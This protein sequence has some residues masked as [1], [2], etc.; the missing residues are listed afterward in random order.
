MDERPAVANLYRR[1]YSHVLVDEA[2]DLS[3]AQY[4]FLRSFCSEAFR[5]IIM[6]GDPNQAIHGYAGASSEYMSHR[7]VADFGLNEN[8]KKRIKYNYRSSKAIIDL[9][10]RVAGISQNTIE[11]YYEGK[12]DF[13][14]FSDESSEAAWVIDKLKQLIH[15]VSEA[16]D[17]ELTLDKVAVLGRNRYVFD[18]IITRLNEEPQFV[19][20]FYL[21]RG[22]E[23]ID[24]QSTTLKIFDLGT[25]ILCN[26][27]AN[28]YQRQLAGILNL[29]DDLDFTAGDNMASLD[30]ALKKSKVPYLSDQIFNAL[31]EA[32]LKIEISINNLTGALDTILFASASITEDNERDLINNDIV[33]WREAWSNYIRTVKSQSKSINDFRRYIAMGVTKNQDHEGLTLASVHTVKGL[34]YYVVFLLGVGQGTFPDYRATDS[35]ALLEEKNNIYVAITRAKREL[36]ISYPKVKSVPWGTKSQQKSEFFRD[37]NFQTIA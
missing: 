28:L 35:S 33:E 6:V 3:F 30:D 25:R 9:A 2:Q 23:V 12:T 4:E 20:K 21:K 24:P 8:Q 7:F 22:T 17:G 34:E 31:R 29:S 27:R 32:W 10:N 36:Y 26:N 13:Y 37:I 16:F 11:S 15:T 14:C 1:I 5:N 19:D 18:E